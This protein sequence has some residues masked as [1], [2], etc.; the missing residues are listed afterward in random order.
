VTSAIPAT[1]EPCHHQRARHS[2]T[3]L[4]AFGCLLVIVAIFICLVL[5]LDPAADGFGQ[6]RS[7]PV[8][9]APSLLMLVAAMA[10][11]IGGTPIVI[12][13]SPVFWSAIALCGLQIGGAIATLQIQQVESAATFLGRGVAAT[14]IFTGML[15]GGD[16]R[17]RDAILRPVATIALLTTAGGAVIAVL[18]GSDLFLTDLVQV[19]H[20]EHLYIVAGLMLWV[21]GRPFPL[22]SWIALALIVYIATASGK[23]TAQLSALIFFMTMFMAPIFI[24]IIDRMRFKRTANPLLVYIMVIAGIAFLLVG[25]FFVLGLLEAKNLATPNDL[26][27]L[28]WGMRWDQFVKSPVIGSLF[29]GS[30]VVNIQI[31]P[32]LQIPTH[33]DVL[34]ILAF[35]GFIG[36]ALF[37]VFPVSI[38]VSNEFWNTFRPVE[39]AR[40]HQLYPGFVFIAYLVVATANP[41]FANPFLSVPVWFAMG[42]LS[43]SRISRKLTHSSSSPVPLPSWRST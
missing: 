38:V 33:N 43:G 2:V 12:H 24:S 25:L 40:T 39:K 10:F 19:L 32:G 9:Y 31:L 3:G 36:L 18:H 16:W 42:V 15:C 34:D 13:R 7:Q 11:L 20:E 35:G 1:H 41:V 37:L 26:R 27:K 6:L 28:L 29:F 4:R 22:A 23:A 30:P 17:L 21:A 14:A 5:N 8:K